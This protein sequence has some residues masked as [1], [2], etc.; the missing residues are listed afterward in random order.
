MSKSRIE[1]ENKRIKYLNP[2]KCYVLIDKDVD[3]NPLPDNWLKDLA[4]KMAEKANPPLDPKEVLKEYNRHARPD[5]PS[6]LNTSIEEGL[7]F[8]YR[9]L[10]LAKVPDTIMAMVAVRLT[11]QLSAC[12]DGFAVR[13]GEIVER[14]HQPV[15]MDDHLYRIR[16]RIV[17]E[18]A[19]SYADQVTVSEGSDVHAFNWPFIIAHRLEFG[20]RPPNGMDTH[21]QG[22]EDFIYTL[23][24]ENLDQNYHPMNLVSLIAEDIKGIFQEQMNYRGETKAQYSLVDTNRWL[25]FLRKV[26]PDLQI[27]NLFIYKDLDIYGTGLVIDINWTSVKNAILRELINKDYFKLNE[28]EKNALLWLLSSDTLALASSSQTPTEMDLSHL[29]G[30]GCFISDVKE[31]FTMLD[32][33]SIDAIDKKKALLAQASYRNTKHL[34]DYYKDL[35]K[36]KKLLMLKRDLNPII[37]DLL[38]E[39]QRSLA[40]IA[41]LLTDFLQYKPF[42][43]DELKDKLDNYF[44]IKI[45]ELKKKGMSDKVIEHR[46]AL[47]LNNLLTNIPKTKEKDKLKQILLSLR[48]VFYELLP[49]LHRESSDSV[50][51]QLL[52]QLKIKKPS[53]KTV[54]KE[55]AKLVPEVKSALVQEDPNQRIRF[56]LDNEPLVA[57]LLPLL[58]LQER[59]NLL[60]STDSK[61]LSLLAQVKDPAFLTS[62]G[63]LLPADQEKIL[64]LISPTGISSLMHVLV[65]A[66]AYAL[67]MLEILSS[68]S[69]PTSLKI[70]LFKTINHE[71]ND[72]CLLASFKHANPEVAKAAIAIVQ[73][74][75]DQE[76]KDILTHNTQQL[77]AQAPVAI[78]P[79]LSAML[80]QFSISHDLTERVGKEESKVAFIKTF[81][82]NSSDSKTAVKWLET[83]FASFSSEALYDVLL[84]FTPM[85][86]D[87][88]ELRFTLID[89]LKQD[90]SALNKLNDAILAASNPEKALE[91]LAIVKLL[92]QFAQLT[93]FKRTLSMVSASIWQKSVSKT[94]TIDYLKLASTLNRSNRSILLKKE[95]LH[96]P[97]ILHPLIDLATIMYDIEPITEIITAFI[98]D[99]SPEELADVLL[100]TRIKKGNEFILLNEIPNKNTKLLPIIFKQLSDR[101]LL[102]TLDIIHKKKTEK[103]LNLS[104]KS[105]EFTKDRLDGFKKLFQSDG[106]NRPLDE[107]ISDYLSPENTLIH[108]LN[109]AVKFKFIEATFTK[110]NLI[111]RLFAGEPDMDAL[112]H[113]MSIFNK[114]RSIDKYSFL[115][116]PLDKKKNTLLLYWAKIAS[117]E[118]FVTIFNATSN[119]YIHTELLN[120]TNNN[121]ESIQGV[122]IEH[123]QQSSANLTPEE[124]VQKLLALANEFVYT[125]NNQKILSRFFQ[126]WLRNDSALKE[127][128]NLMFNNAIAAQPPI[129]AHFH[130]IINLL[131]L[132]SRNHRYDLLMKPIDIEGNN[133]LLWILQQTSNNPKQLLNWRN[134]VFR[135]MTQEQAND[136]KQFK[137][138]ANKTPQNH[139]DKINARKL[140]A[141]I[142]AAEEHKTHR[143][144]LDHLASGALTEKIL[145]RIMDQDPVIAEKIQ[146]ALDSDVS[147]ISDTLAH[148]HYFPHHL[149]MRYLLNT[150]NQVEHFPLNQIQAY[151]EALGKLDK[152]DRILLLS[153]R[154]NHG[155]NS[156]LRKI[157]QIVLHTPNYYILYE[158]LFKDFSP[159]EKAGILIH[160]HQL[161][162][163]S[164]KRNNNPL[165]K[166]AN[167]KL[168]LQQ[169]FNLNEW[170]ESNHR[171]FSKARREL[172]TFGNIIQHGYILHHV[173]DKPFIDILD[174][175]GDEI[176]RRSFRALNKDETK[177]KQTLRELYRVLSERYFDYKSGV[178]DR[179]ACLIDWKMQI[180][181]YRDKPIIKKHTGFKDFFVKLL[182]LLPLGIP[183]III[184]NYKNGFFFQPI[185]ETASYKL[186]NS[187]NDSLEDDEDHNMP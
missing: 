147:H 124:T 116:E 58:S 121:Q 115:R 84:S 174:T 169:E 95:S 105:L 177:K 145:A 178:G 30:R 127:K 63:E 33:I 80:D 27:D 109:Y 26:V 9:Q 139:M 59:I 104:M 18:V 113:Y 166:D 106:K 22:G 35:C 129:P 135:N 83:V 186:L 144:I 92:P 142:Q 36:E 94:L 44:S 158:T 102:K 66:P 88:E 56:I 72:N 173:D 70:V 159:D 77:I 7:A 62:L 71:T 151:C 96:E 168:R 32:C 114:L 108:S 29:A 112:H 55:P 87:K 119:I 51:Q 17:H 180:Q 137:N 3:N 38:L 184:S 48:P 97:M 123:W 152:T 53:L 170:G 130:A 153:E 73:N 61:G 160:S 34:I 101:E 141:I 81:L 68:S 45:N 49:T 98:A 19:N 157:H 181:T 125:S 52:Q 39:K 65:N 12:S 136:I 5:N 16:Y 175:L 78:L 131:P 133:L 31:L 164:G 20:V 155:E 86:Q 162:P 54:L 57:E 46:L 110:N 6:A 132:L 143:I 14:L 21:I 43:Q 11:E 47:D 154:L 15:S 149:Q 126:I 91:A 187:M 185:S 117:P 75:P 103:G 163:I 148:I 23:L 2:I 150:M 100:S 128:I 120:Q 76:K 134:E 50:W 41:P 111:R 8:I 99:L 146:N 60:H 93:Y 172:G 79:Q 42:G 156:L 122:I 118:T 89:W 176:R 179:Q 64:S 24:T 28:P 138:N 171:A 107:L 67:P 10:I 13:V 37:I 165:F 25:D 182:A 82:Q 161:K 40:Q 183:A 85:C 4:I 167:I 90:S 69:L 74:F 1:L 140:I